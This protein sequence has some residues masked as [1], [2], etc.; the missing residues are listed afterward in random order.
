VSAGLANSTTGQRL[1][2]RCNNGSGMTFTTSTGGFYLQD[3]RIWGNSVTL[4]T[5][6][7]RT[8]TSI[9]NLPFIAGQT[10]TLDLNVR[11]LGGCVIGEDPTGD[12]SPSKAQDCPFWSLV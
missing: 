7:I 11:V 9:S 8:G 12:T 10:I 1:A 6:D 2:I 3:N 5:F 4:N